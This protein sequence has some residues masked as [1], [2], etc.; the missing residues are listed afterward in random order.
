MI[1][2]ITIEVELS[3]T[4]VRGTLDKYVNGNWLPGEPSDVENFK[5]SIPMTKQNMVAQLQNDITVLLDDML[6]EKLKNE[7]I[8]ADEEDL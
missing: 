4:I 3:G 2:E 7:Y 6:I 1:T 5:V 8:E